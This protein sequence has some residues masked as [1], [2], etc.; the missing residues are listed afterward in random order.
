MSHAEGAA[1]NDKY[2]RVQLTVK[3]IGDDDGPLVLADVTVNG[4][5]LKLTGFNLQWRAGGPCTVTLHGFPGK[6][7]LRGLALVEIGEV[8]A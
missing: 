1:M 3:S 6:L 2:Q 8:D 7:D 4:Q 5:K